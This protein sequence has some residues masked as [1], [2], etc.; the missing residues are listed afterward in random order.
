MFQ[1]LMTFFFHV[2]LQWKYDAVVYDG[3]GFTW[4][5]SYFALI[6]YIVFMTTEKC[7]TNK[8]QPLSCINRSVLQQATGKKHALINRTSSSLNTRSGSYNTTIKNYFALFSTEERN[9][10]I[11]RNYF[12]GGDTEGWG[13]H[14]FQKERTILFVWRRRSVE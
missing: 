14:I 6:S 11:F 5:Q 9:M 7:P 10:P 1:I 4:I 8:R 13:H 3:Y 2:Y 12:H